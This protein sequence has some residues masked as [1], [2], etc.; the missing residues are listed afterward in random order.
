MNRHNEGQSDEW[1]HDTTMHPRFFG[2]AILH[3]DDGD[4]SCAAIG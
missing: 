2:D 1:Y 4:T 3:L